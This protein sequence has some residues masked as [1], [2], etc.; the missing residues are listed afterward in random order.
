MNKNIK[1]IL[2][3]KIVR[4]GLSKNEIK[5]KILK[6]ISQNNNIQNNLKIYA[7][8]LMVKHIQRDMYVSRKNKVCLYTGKRGG[9]LKGFSYSRYKVK[10]L[11]L[12]N[13]LTNVKKHNW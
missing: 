4:I 11:I 8:F 2:R 5:K 9:F 12:N 6:S 7:N 3:E 1:N 13:K 10:S